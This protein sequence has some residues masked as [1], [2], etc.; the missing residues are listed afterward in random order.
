MVAVSSRQK[1][2]NERRHDPL[3]SCIYIVEVLRDGCQ[4]RNEEVELLRIEM[5]DIRE[6]SWSRGVSGERE[7]ET[8]REREKLNEG[9]RV[10]ERE[11]ETN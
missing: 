5:K 6:I 3:L 10:R 7:R 11:R 2:Q 4:H 8:E 9:E 1:G